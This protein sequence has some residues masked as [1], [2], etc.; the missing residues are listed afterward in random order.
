MNDE[1]IKVA[2]CYCVNKG[3]GY[4]DDLV[5]ELGEDIV[6]NFRLSGFIRIGYTRERKTWSVT[7]LAQSYKKDL[8]W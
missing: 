8:Q 1:M 7:N 6:D 2:V 3:W 5:Y 4:Y